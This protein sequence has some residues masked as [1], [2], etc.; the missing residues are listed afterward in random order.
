MRVSALMAVRRGRPAVAVALLVCLFCA[1]SAG[2]DRQGEPL[3]RVNSY[4]I[5]AAELDRWLR[6]TEAA[7]QVPVAGTEMGLLEREELE[8]QRRKEALQN[9]IE[10]RV[11]SD[12]ARQRYLGS[13]SAEQTLAK[14]ADEE[15]RKFEERAGSKLK[16][17][18]L[19][20]QAGLTVEQFK[21]IQVQNVLAGQLLWDEVY[22]RLSVTPAEIRSYYD[23]HPDE[24]KEPKTV[25]YREILFPVADQDDEAPQ[26]EAAEAA[27]R[28]VH[29][30]T[31]FAAVADRCSADRDRYRGGL[32][33]VGVP[34]EASDWLPP[35]VEGLKAD[36]VSE[37]RRVGA[38]F[39]IV[40]LEEVRPPRVA[41]FEE[42]QGM[43]KA[44]L[45]ERR[46][47]AAHAEY[48]AKVTRQARIECYQAA[49]D[50][51]LP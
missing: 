26:R 12:L 39:S 16:A 21:E 20:S 27:L 41:P 29:S 50:L 36:Q 14:I 2:Q 3:V 4:L 51:G 40:K 45:L 30:G 35:A 24:F 47:V 33:V 19:L 7:G 38:G 46:R 6:A 28:E 5:T 25:V 10:R 48:V 42:A 37:V 15:L 32:H 17:V 9:L 23:E 44:K 13:D 22:S 18:Q 31:D 1:A 49:V 11:L 43:I 8:A 34:D